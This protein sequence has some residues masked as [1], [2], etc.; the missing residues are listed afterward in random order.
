[1]RKLQLSSLNDQF[2]ALQIKFGDKDLH[3][4][5]G[6]GCINRPDICFIFMNPTGR[7]ISADKKWNGLRAPWLG[8]K[9]I[10]KLFF[11]LNFINK[12]LFN[13]IQ[14]LNSTNWT[15]EFSFSVYQALAD[16]KIYVTNLS[17]ATQVDARALNDSHYKNYLTLLDEE[18]SVIKPKIIF[19]F[20][21][22]VSSLVLNEKILVSKCRNVSFVKKINKHE[23]IVQ[24]VFYPV[25]QG[26]RNLATAI[27]DIKKVTG[28]MTGYKK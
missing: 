14:S 18:I 23:F 19:T 20:G 27:A 8:T 10:W 6:A 12:E 1:M 15:P 5:Y 25:G 7:N 11:G 28:T 26:M 13:K 24:P 17:K 21:N 16:K 22:Q 2:D 4:I 9:N 3:S